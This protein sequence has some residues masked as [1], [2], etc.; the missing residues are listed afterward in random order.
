MNEEVGGSLS[1]RMSGEEDN[2]E[3]NVVKARTA[4]TKRREL[5]VLR[6]CCKHF[7]DTFMESIA[8]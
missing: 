6:H 2:T 1:L 7:T 3:C 8:P 5:T 4:L